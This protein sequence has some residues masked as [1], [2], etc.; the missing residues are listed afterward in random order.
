M[1][2]NLIP[3]RPFTDG[4]NAIVTNGEAPDMLMDFGIIVL[5]NGQTWQSDVDLERVILLIQGDVTLEYGD[6]SKRV[7]RG[8]CFDFA[9][10]VLSVPA[11]TAVK[12]TSHRDDTQLTYNATPNEKKFPA[13]LYAP[14]ESPDEYR[15]AG[16]MKEASTRIVRTTF[17]LHNAPHSNFVIG[18]VIGYPGKWSSYPPHHHPQPEIYYYKTMPEGG[19]AYAELNEDVYKLR[20]DDTL[21]IEGGQTHSH[22]TYPG[23]ALWYLWVI[24]HIDGN[25]YDIQTF[26]PEHKWVEGPGAVIWPD[27]A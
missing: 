10:W 17:N 9:P 25:P 21:L 6:E 27:K 12:I 5:Q 7:E 15:G 14:E 23:Y 13:R 2:Q 1:H 16:T 24:R 20:G 11:G 19:R 18:E 3:A 4:Y 8:N 26:V 22:V